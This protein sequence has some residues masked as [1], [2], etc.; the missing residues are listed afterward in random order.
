MTSF[1]DLRSNI[2]TVYHQAGTNAC[3]AHATVNMLDAMYDSAGDSKRFSRAWI[4]WWSRVNSGRAGQDVGA[5]YNDL[6]F[7]LETKGVILE[8]QQ[9]WTDRAANF[10]P[11][12]AVSVVGK[13]TTVRVAISVD[14]IKARLVF[15]YPVVIGM[16]MVSDFNSLY[17][18]RD[19]RKT[20]FNTNSSFTGTKHAMCIVGFD[21][22]CE[23]LLIENS[24]GPGFADGGFFGLPYSDL[25]SVGEEL[26]TVSRIYGFHPKKAE[27][28]VAIPYLLV[29]Q[30]YTDYLSHN[31]PRLRSAILRA[32]ETGGIQ[33]AI[34]ICKAEGVTDKLL[35]NMFSWDRFSVRKF[36]EDPKNAGINWD[37][38]IFST[39]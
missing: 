11:K 1:V 23:R 14:A 17:G 13:I 29:A 33:A 5:V 12:D 21:D 25:R 32:F 30:D 27:D 6:K 2:E 4:W 26:W 20:K 10:P 19:W 15:G 7:A 35:E 16:E 22:S 36:Q 38:F 39:T 34:D 37:G 9:P 18:Q 31:K 24:Y 8:S 3:T 28:H